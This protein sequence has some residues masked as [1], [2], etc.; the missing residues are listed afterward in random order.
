MTGDDET[1]RGVAQTTNP[2]N[3]SLGD[4]TALLATMLVR[5]GSKKGVL[6]RHSEVIKV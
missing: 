6:G 1:V 4:H 3:I 5:Y 2:A